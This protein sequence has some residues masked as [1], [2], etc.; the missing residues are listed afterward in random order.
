[1][2]RYAY[3]MCELKSRDLDARLLV[4]AHLV[5]RGMSVV[6]GQQWSMI[7]NAAH[8][9]AGV[10]LFKSANTIQADAARRVKA[11][12]HRIVFM[13]EEVL[14]IVSPYIIRQITAPD[15]LEIADVFLFQSEM[16]REILK[17][18][19]PIVGSLRVDLL[20]DYRELYQAEAD[21][22]RRDGRYL[23]INTN[24][25]LV[26]NSFADPMTILET[27][28]KAGS[29]EAETAE[30]KAYIRSWI[31]VETRNKAE[32]ERLLA[33]LQGKLGDIRIVLRSHPTENPDPWT[34]F[35]EVHVVSGS[36]PT[37]WLL[38]AEFIVH[39]NSTTGME[40][41]LLNKPVLN[42]N[43]EPNTPFSEQYVMNHAPPQAANA[44]QAASYIIRALAQPPRSEP[45]TWLPTFPP[46]CANLVADEIA[47]RAIEGPAITRW[48]RGE[49]S[50]HQIKK[51]TVSPQE[52]VD[53]L[54]PFLV[55]S[56]CSGVECVM[57]DDSIFLLKP[58]KT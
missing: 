42:M 8:A 14:A 20:R 4:A 3:L 57:L 11:C 28:R 15:V 24:Y 30:G 23:L 52:F 37:G 29:I 25:G 18:S 13:D 16:H 38:G 31:D 54:Q 12:G 35:P 33:L 55:R 26:N 22:F 56:G 48:D 50:D 2:P 9:P 44:E 47:A 36:A 21:A 39:T 49:R 41:A 53:R 45:A 19:G 17:G 7:V 6:V 40:A 32:M 58:T 34:K 5:A 10:F 43:P 27:T 1:M 51:F 46:Q